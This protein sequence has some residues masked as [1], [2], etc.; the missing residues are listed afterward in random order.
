MKND[1]LENV[2]FDFIRY[3]N[4]WED[5]DLLL[6]SFELN[7]KSKVISIASGGD[8]CFS[9]AAQAPEYVVA[10]DVS[11]VQLFLVELKMAAIKS[12]DRETYMGFVGFDPDENRL[13]RYRQL[14][15]KLTTKAQTYWDGN[16]RA[17][18][19]GIIHFGKFE[20]YF[21]L[22][23]KNFLE[24]VHTQDVVDG[25][26]APKTEKDQIYFYNEY[27]FDPRW[28]EM[29]SIFFGTE[30]LGEKGR[31]PE[32]MKQIKGSV[33]ETILKREVE[34]LKSIYC[35]TN[36]FLFYILNNKF[37]E[38]HLPHYVRSENYH[39]VK[40]NMDRIILKQGLMGKVAQDFKGATHYNLSN[41]FEYMDMEHFESEGKAII[42]SAAKQA[43][44][45][46]WNFMMDRN[47]AD[48]LKEYLIYEKEL[49]EKLSAKDKGYFYSRFIVNKVI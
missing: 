7:E 16:Q 35:Q 25:L 10:V 33:S 21:Q 30:M 4:C 15:S 41:I 23:K 19:E 47:L 34:H 46:Y 6:E 13:E 29:H 27:W 5:V 14:T 45:G 18:D 49:S 11:E 28:K 40:E 36:P 31:D 37:D 32:F 3:S 17:I 9:L 2:D 12:F 43:K 26:F 39:L 44:L 24:K 1:H 20:R 8:N 38:N 22:F 42:Q 48:Q